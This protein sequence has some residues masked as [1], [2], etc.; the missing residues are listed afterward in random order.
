MKSI[1][2][3]TLPVSLLVATL[4]EAQGVGKC[5]V[6]SSFSTC[7]TINEN[8]STTSRSSCEKT[9]SC[10]WAVRSHVDPFR[11]Q[12][13]PLNGSRVSACGNLGTENQCRKYATECAWF[14]VGLD[15]DSAAVKESDKGRVKERRVPYDSSGT[16]PPVQ[17]PRFGNFFPTKAPS[18]APTTPQPT[19]NPTTAMP[20]VAPTTSTPS[21]SAPSTSAPFTSPP[22]TSAPSTSA[23]SIR[24]TDAPT[25]APTFMPTSAP[26]ASINNNSPSPPSVVAEANV[27]RGGRVGDDEQENDQDD[28]DRDGRLGDDN[29]EDNDGNGRTIGIVVAAV[30]ATSLVAGGAILM[31]RSMVP[32]TP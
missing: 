17:V 22:S 24:P 23:P 13:Y 27:D 29:D 14:V 10:T 20:T 15:D 8:L 18:S 1:M 30:G 21:T 5:Q 3:L 2:L 28:Q 16:S 4:V 12:C 9:L 6:R 32:P 31:R 26:A 11:Q 25:H 19:S 7:Y